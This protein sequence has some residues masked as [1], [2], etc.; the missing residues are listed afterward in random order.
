MTS[1]QASELVLRILSVSKCSRK[2]KAELMAFLELLMGA[3]PSAAA[4]SNV[5]EQP[6]EFKPEE[7]TINLAEAF[8]FDFPKEFNLQVEGQDGLRKMKIFPDGVSE[9]QPVKTEA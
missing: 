9:E 6:N 7:N 2:S 5:V 3:K 1:Q 4:K 8:H